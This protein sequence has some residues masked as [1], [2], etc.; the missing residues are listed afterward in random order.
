MGGL[1]INFILQS[2]FQIWESLKK[3][4]NYIQVVG[5]ATPVQ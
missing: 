4:V 2:K 1:L 5:L 3:T